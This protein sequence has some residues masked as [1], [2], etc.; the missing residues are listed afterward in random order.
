MQIFQGGENLDRDSNNLR[1]VKSS[2]RCRTDPLFQRVTVDK[3]HDEKM[4]LAFSKLVVDA[5]NVRIVEL[6]Q[7]FSLAPKSLYGILP[8]DRIAEGI[9]HFC[10]STE[11]TSKVQIRD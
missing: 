7:N 6:N 3:L 1:F 2:M 10:Q 4:L 5:G 11:S 9:N 8:G